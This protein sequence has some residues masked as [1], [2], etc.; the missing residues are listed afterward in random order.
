MI[1]SGDGDGKMVKMVMIEITEIME[2]M[3]TVQGRGEGKEDV[4]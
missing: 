3:V 2:M 1:V 4:M